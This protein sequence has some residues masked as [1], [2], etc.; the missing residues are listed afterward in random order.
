MPIPKAE[1]DADRLLQMLKDVTIESNKF[2]EY[3]NIVSKVTITEGLIP[4]GGLSFITLSELTE[5]SEGA[6]VAPW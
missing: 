1:K 3:R 6:P 2:I 4:R 5:L